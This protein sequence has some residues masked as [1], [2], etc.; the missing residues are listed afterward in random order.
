VAQD[1]LGGQDCIFAL[2]GFA[3]LLA[4]VVG[5][6]MFRWGASAVSAGKSAEGGNDV[7]P[8]GG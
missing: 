3:G 4:F 7:V 5:Y 1:D 8:V 2:L 6:T